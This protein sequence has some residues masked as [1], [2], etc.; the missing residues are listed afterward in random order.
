METV[1]FSIRVIQTEG[2][3]T[4]TRPS[5]DKSYGYPPVRASRRTSGRNPVTVV[6]WSE[7]IKS[8]TESCVVTA[9]LMRGR[10]DL[11]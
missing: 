7:V 3:L 2:R 10:V 5:R 6:I 8:A 11:G 4:R 9:P 1:A